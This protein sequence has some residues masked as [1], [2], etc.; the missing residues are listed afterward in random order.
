VWS[1]PFAS[2]PK[3]VTGSVATVVEITSDIFKFGGRSRLDTFSIDL[4]RCSEVEAHRFQLALEGIRK[5]VNGFPFWQRRK[6]VGRP[7]SDERT[8]M[9][10]FLIHQL[11]STTFLDAEGLLHMLS[12][13]FQIDR[14]PDHSVLCRAMSSR[15]WTS[16]L[17]RFFSFVIERLPKMD[18]IRAPSE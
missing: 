13:Y 18:A 11:F 3:K 6:R 16:L 12:L 1:D 8:L 4:G 10:G 5:N 2:C 17:E 9:I 14:V 7:S 15:R